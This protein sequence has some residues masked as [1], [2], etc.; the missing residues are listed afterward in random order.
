MNLLAKC[1]FFSFHPKIEMALA[2]Y[3]RQQRL[4]TTMLGI[5]KNI[6]SDRG[7]GFISGEDGH[8]Y[9]FHIS[10]CG[11]AWEVLKKGVR[12]E[13][14]LDTSKEKPRAVDLKVI[15]GGGS[16][17]PRKEL[18][19]YDGDVFKLDAEARKSALND[20]ARWKL[21]AKLDDIKRYFFTVPELK[22]ITTGD[23]S[24]VIG[25]KGTGKTA[26]V[27][28]LSDHSTGDMFVT[29]PC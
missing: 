9:F 29:R 22:K 8:D 3:R 1:Q 23:A 19:P 13:F 12:V 17:L 6:L 27:Q 24:Y 4:G 25:R 26:L 7:F 5:I 15:T 20:I 11:R 2:L 28:Y 16:Y 10:D 21:E 18:Q 14:H